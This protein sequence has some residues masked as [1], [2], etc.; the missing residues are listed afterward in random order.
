MTSE[1]ERC[2]SAMRCCS[3]LKIQV[4]EPNFFNNTSISVYESI[5]WK[6]SYFLRTNWTRTNRRMLENC[7]YCQ[8]EFIIWTLKFFRIFWTSLELWISSLAHAVLLEWLNFPTMLQ[9]EVLLVLLLSEVCRS[10]QKKCCLPPP[11]T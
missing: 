6:K 11:W 8:D 10:H 4:L 9:D 5:Y 7:R 1:K 3:R 2:R